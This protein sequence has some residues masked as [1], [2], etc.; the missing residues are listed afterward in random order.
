MAGFVWNRY[1]D[2][3]YSKLYEY[4]AQEHFAREATPGSVLI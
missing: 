2:E 4:S 1:F 3:A